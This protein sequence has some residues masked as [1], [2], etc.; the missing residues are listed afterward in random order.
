[1]G[2]VGPGGTPVGWISPESGNRKDFPAT[3]TTG[4]DGKGKLTI[5]GGNPMNFRK[6]IDGQ[7][8]ALKFAA[9][10]APAIP[11][12]NSILSLLVHDVFDDA[13]S[14]ANISPIMAQYAK[15]YP[16]MASLGIEL[17]NPDSLRANKAALLQVFGFP[18]EDPRYMPVVRDLSVAKLNAIVAWLEAQPDPS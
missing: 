3:V 2:R 5:A 14:W 8:Y 10:R 6:F 13:P 11:D 16:I 12:S 1:V 9:E 17:D 4:S 18:I 15:L 7:V